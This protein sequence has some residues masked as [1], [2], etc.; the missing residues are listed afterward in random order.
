MS[1]S[2]TSSPK[3]TNPSTLEAHDLS[4]QLQQNRSVTEEQLWPYHMLHLRY[5]CAVFPSCP[6]MC[7][8]QKDP[9]TAGMSVCST[10][11]ANILKTMSEEDYD[12]SSIFDENTEATSG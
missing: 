2:S 10:V 11:L 5:N 3:D 1:A 6:V 8:T 12:L 4:K 7:G 9:A